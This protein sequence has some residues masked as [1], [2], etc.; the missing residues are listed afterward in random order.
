MVRPL[1]EARSEFR[2]REG[3]SFPANGN[4]VCICFTGVSSSVYQASFSAVDPTIP[5]QSF[6][7]TPLG[8]TLPWAAQRL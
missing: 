1:S 2:S 8:S 6:K 7:T 5:L 3:V 4:V